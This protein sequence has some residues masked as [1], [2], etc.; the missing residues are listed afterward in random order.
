MRGDVAEKVDFAKWRYELGDLDDEP[1]EPYEESG[2]DDESG[3]G[4][5]FFK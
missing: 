3:E 5:A 2:P 1:I 4:S